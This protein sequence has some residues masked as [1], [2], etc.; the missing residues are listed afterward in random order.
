[1]KQ[2]FF[3][4]NLTI[5]ISLFV[6]AGIA[7]VAG[8]NDFGSK[9]SL[10]THMEE[11]LKEALTEVTGTDKLV[12]VV[13]ADVDTSR[14][15]SATP[16]AQHRKGTLTKKEESNALVLPGVPAKKE[17]G[18]STT[19]TA[20]LNLPDIPSVS[21]AVQGSGSMMIRRLAV[22]ILVD[23]D[24]PA[25]MMEL[26]RDVAT[27]ICDLNQSRGDRLDIKQVD[28]K[29]INF[30]WGSLFYPPHLYW[31]ILII[32][33]GFFLL[34][35]SLF[36]MNPYIRFS[37]SGQNIKMDMLKDAASG[38]PLQGAEAVAPSE[39]IPGPSVSAE[40]DKTDKSV[41]PFSFV[42]EKHLR[43]LS[44]L[45]SKEPSLDIG[46]IMNYLDTEL[47]M[48]LL[49]SFP[50]EKQAEITFA[51]SGIEEVNPEKITMLE[52][53][54]KDKLGYIVGGEDKVANILGLVSDEVRE[55]VFSLIENKDANAA[56]RLRK[57]V[58]DFDTLMKELPSHGI[59]A[60]FRQIDISLFAQVLKSSPEDIQKKV[61]EALTAGAAERLKQEI[62]LSRPLPAARLKKE[63]QNIM[64][65]IRRMIREGLVEVK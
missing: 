63:K 27:S 11:R 20:E 14:Q 6:I 25:S 12:V 35:A 16:S 1:M 58:K 15:R 2:R 31:V 60:M 56:K 44:I 59:Q 9:I 48:K 49:E 13:N 24:V 53:K 54:I 32:T 36:L 41:I 51:I 42:R 65:I 55:K 47:A 3:I 21:G 18:K 23:R 43:D 10:E 33:V 30:H 37:G 19:Q 8:A 34:A 50:A 39:E 28:I 38:K 45:L 57:Q 29:K 40:K 64:I 62:D 7:A 22:T 5:A 61:L 4:I 17:I 52:D 46:I 26:V